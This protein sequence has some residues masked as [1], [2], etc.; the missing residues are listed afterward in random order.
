MIALGILMYVVA[1]MAAISDLEDKKP[2]WFLIDL[3]F[4]PIGVLRFFYL[5]IF[6]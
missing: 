5:W 4:P 2:G 3:I 1:I 6:E